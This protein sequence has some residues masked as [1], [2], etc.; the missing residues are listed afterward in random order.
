M[1]DYYDQLTNQN[2][3][4]NVY[5]KKNDSLW[6]TIIEQHHERPNG[7]GYPKGLSDGQIRPETILVSKVDFYLSLIMPRAYRDPILS[8]EALRRIYKTAS[9]DDKTII[10]TFIRQLGIYPPGT[11][12]KLS[13]HEV[14][15]VTRR[16][17]KN[18]THP[19]VVSIGKVKGSENFKP[20]ARN[21]MGS[22]IRIEDAYSFDIRQPL[23]LQQIW[24][25]Q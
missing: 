16:S 1:Y 14:A 18:A 22:G 4:L 7:S 19:K 6:L 10:S 17:H 21:I 15:I 24:S 5:Q 23:D 13:N 3:A 20:V 11:F 9:E 2:C 8:R 25:L 12:V